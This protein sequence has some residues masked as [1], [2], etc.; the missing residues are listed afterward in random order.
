M[1]DLSIGMEGHRELSGVGDLHYVCVDVTKNDVAK[2][3]DILG[4]LSSERRS[5]DSQTTAWL[6]FQVGGRCK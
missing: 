5:K 6:S 2:V 4:Q 1:Q 3:Q